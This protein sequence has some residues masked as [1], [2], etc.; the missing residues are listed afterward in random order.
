MKTIQ[1][2]PN[3]YKRWGWLILIPSMIVGLVCL[4]NGKI[5]YEVELPVLYNSGFMDDPGFFVKTHVDV[6][7]NGVG[8]LVIIGAVLVGFSREKEEDE[9]L[10]QLRLRAVF[11]SLIVSYTIFFV[12]MLTVFGLQFFNLMIILL[13]FPILIYIFLFNFYLYN[14]K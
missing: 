9:Y 2:L 3:S 6:V 8:L 5:S 12:L 10:Q 4:F 13:Y 1:L 14:E 11:W 7:T